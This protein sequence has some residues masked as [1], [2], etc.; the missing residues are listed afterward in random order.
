[1]AFKPVENSL[2]TRIIVAVIPW[3]LGKGF[4]RTRSEDF[5]YY[6]LL[7]KFEIATFGLSPGGAS[8]ELKADVGVYHSHQKTSSIHCVGQQRYTGMKITAHVAA[9]KDHA[10]VQH[11]P[12]YKSYICEPIIGVPM[13]STSHART[14]HAPGW[15]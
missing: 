2:S 1:M 8:S 6:C 5:Q 11:A 4:E 12:L 7:I 9:Y 10:C 3:R 13:L 15:Y 14:K